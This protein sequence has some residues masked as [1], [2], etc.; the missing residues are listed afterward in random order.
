M[1]AAH[2]WGRI[3]GMDTAADG[4]VYLA[5]RDQH[6]IKKLAPDGSVSVFAGTGTPGFSGDDGAAT[7]AN[8]NSP[9]DVAVASDGSVYLY[10]AN[11]RIRRVLP[12]GTIR[13]VAGVGHPPEPLTLPT[14]GSLALAQHIELVDIAAAPDG[15]IYATARGEDGGPWNYVLR[16]WNDGTVETFAGDGCYSNCPNR[17]DGLAPLATA[18]DSMDAIDVDDNGTIY[19]NEGGY[20]VRTIQNGVVGTAAGCTDCFTIEVPDGTPALRFWPYPMRSVVAGPDGLYLNISGFTILRIQPPLPSSAGLSFVIPSMAGDEFFEF[21]SSGKHLKTRHALTGADLLTLGYDSASRLQSLTNEVGLT[22]TIE[23][24][25]SGVAT[26]IISPFGQRT[27]LEINPSGYLTAITGPTGDAVSIGYGTGGLLT[28]F[29]DARDGTSTMIYDAAGRLEHDEGADNSTHDL[30]RTGDNASFTVARTTA[31]GRTTTY[32]AQLLA[33]GSRIITTTSPDGT[34]HQATTRL[35]GQFAFSAPDGTTATQTE[36]PETRFGLGA[37]LVSRTTVLPSGLSN[38][39]TESRSYTGLSPS[40]FLQFTSLSTSK[41]GWSST[42]TQSSRT[43]LNRSPLN[44]TTT[45]V[46]DALGRTVSTQVSGLAPTEYFYDA[47]GRL[48][49]VVQS[50]RA[51]DFTYFPTGTPAAGYLS[52]VTDP[53]GDATV[54][55]R[56]ALGRTLTESRGGATTQLTWDPNGNLATVTPPSKPAHGMAYTPANLLASYD[57]P[58]AGLPSA[59]TAYTYDLDRMLR[60][61]TRQTAVQIA[62]T[63]D[64]AGRLDTVAFPGGLLNYDYYPASTPSGAGKTSDI[65][66]PYG[67]DLHFTYDGMLAAS[68]TWS[69]AISGSVA[70]AYNTDFNKILETVN[71]TSGS[72]QAVFG[73]DFDQLLTCASPT[74]C[75]PPGSDALKLTRHAQNGL[76]TTIALGNTSEA[77]TYNNFGELARQT[78]TYTGVAPA[79]VDIKYHTT[80]APRDTLGRISVKTETI[81]GITDDFQYFYDTRRRLTDVLRNGELAEHFEYDQNGNRTLGYNLDAETEYV[82]TYDTQDRLLS[83][84]PWT[85]T[86]TANGELETKTNTETD[87]EWAFHYDALGNLLSVGLPNGDLVEYLVD[88]F[89]RRVGKKKNGVLLKQWIYRDALKPVAELDGSGALVSEFVYGSKGNVPDYVRRGGATYRVISDQLGSPRYVVNMANA[90][91]VPFTATYAAFG[92]VVGMGLDWMPFGFAGGIYDSDTDL[93]RFG[94]RDWDTVVGRW[95]SKDPLRFNGGDSNLFEYV[96]GDPINLADPEGTGPLQIADCL[97]KGYSLSQCFNFERQLA[98]QNWGILCGGDQPPPN[99]PVFPES[100]KPEAPYCEAPRPREICRYV[101]HSEQNCFYICKPSGTL[102]VTPRPAH[103]VTGEIPDNDNCPRTAA[104]P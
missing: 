57:P 81:G 63:P 20:R 66:G 35:D 23:R 97:L 30:V 34:T 89:G 9:R 17:E 60:T 72:A 59:S 82:G 55:S 79:L 91:D 62:R 45:R 83:Y 37:P 25:P 14:P 93:V 2:N 47:A 26:A 4:S 85:F 104:G 21:D 58:P 102:Q 94:A 11:E 74:T 88:G 39:I 53:T 42:Y 41:A 43:F 54:Y 78:A 69:G 51:T 1:A 15:S 92:A 61:E 70:W 12:D 16:F 76:T 50:D 8:L 90:G 52:G 103:P 33:D 95:T 64:T 56:D 67:T 101:N 40:N 36:S 77:L 19:V 18:L 100:P 7:A 24:T 48:E 31:L 49:S 32:G 22:T 29:T 44:R 75:S 6:V 13:T 3:E 5:I 84:G 65:H 28:S 98:C 46:I 99:Q 27:E 86:Y 38:T 73:Y 68:T 10:D 80:G 96:F 87:D 71:G